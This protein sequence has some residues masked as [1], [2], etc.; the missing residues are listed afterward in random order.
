MTRK[1]N[2]KLSEHNS[3]SLIDFGELQTPFFQFYYLFKWP[4]FLKKSTI[5]PTRNNWQLHRKMG[6]EEIGDE[7]KS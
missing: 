6:H 5:F 4:I 7:A 1:E 2:I 3:I